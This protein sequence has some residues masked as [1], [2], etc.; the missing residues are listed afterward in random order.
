MR[1]FIPPA[2]A[3]LASA[4][5]SRAQEQH[6]DADYDNPCKSFGIDFQD[7]GKYF[8]NISSSDPFTFVSTFEGCK[9]DFANNILVDPNGDEYLCSDTAL[10]PDDVYQMATCP[11][12]KNQLWTGPWSVIIISNNGDEGEPIAYMRDF[13]LSV[14]IPVTTTVT[15]TVT[16]TATITPTTNVTSTQV[17]TDFSTQTKFITSP[18]YTKSRTVTITPKRTTTTK[19]KTLGTVTKKRFKV[20]PTIVTK[21]KTKTCSV[22]R[23]QRTR[24]PWCT[25]QPTLVT[26][27]ALSEGPHAVPT[28]TPKPRGR[29]DAF[30]RVSND[31]A[32]R[33]AERAARLAEEDDELEKRGLDSEIATVFETNTDLFGKSTVNTTLSSTVTLVNVV[34]STTTVVQTTTSTVYKG[35]TRTIATVTLPTPTKTRT[36][37]TWAR[38][39]KTI[40]LRPTVTKTTKW[41][42]ASSTAICRAKG[43][44]L[45]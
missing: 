3:L 4:S 7:K 31:R 12:E 21:T 40:T 29:R 27:A 36:R 10:T 17:E 26:A 14:G 11:L 35:I 15:P 2:I 16:I 45:V 20:E 34:P 44:K 33:L 41:A 19:T 32:E 25:I 5:R 6:D 22:P 30:R 38:T 13:S 18:A 42:P 1:S 23:R 37:Y 9:K 39:T 28:T 8:Q 43:G 24:D